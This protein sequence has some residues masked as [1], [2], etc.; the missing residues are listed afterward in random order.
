MNEIQPFRTHTC[1]YY[2]RAVTTNAQLISYIMRC[3][4]MSILMN[5]KHPTTKV[6]S[7]LK[8]LQ[9]CEY[10]SIS[11]IIIYTH[12]HTKSW[13]WTALERTVPACQS[14]ALWV[15]THSCWRSGSPSHWSAANKSASSMSRVNSP[16]P[17]SVVD[18]SLP[19]SSMSSLWHQTHHFHSRDDSSIFFCLWMC[20]Y[21]FARN[22]VCNILHAFC[23]QML[24]L[25]V[26]VLFSVVLLK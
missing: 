12:N 25:V 14:V 17:F 21:V 8:S 19:F 16:W 3:F 1:T 15:T 6:N 11:I 18:S 2:K 4:S 24:I 10:S 7:G 13:R 26:N 20:T 22:G 23:S 5:C 9:S